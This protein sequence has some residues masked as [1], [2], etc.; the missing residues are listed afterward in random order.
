MATAHLDHD[1]LVRVA[2]EVAD[3]DGWP[4]LT[5]SRVAEAVRRHVTS[6]YGH[7]DGLEGLRREV[8]LLALEELAEALWEAALGR[9]G[10]DAL[11][12]ILDVY[13]AYQREHPGRADALLSISPRDR[14]IRRLAER[15][16][17]PFYATLRSYGLDDRAAV[18]AQ[19]VIS[20]TIRGFGISESRGHYGTRRDADATF[21]QVRELFL[22]ALRHGGWPVPPG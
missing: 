4:N 22:V 12:A 21:A 3:R 8:Q 7:V 5:M 19:R 18:L 14:E 1:E 13:R 6:L 17:A 20:A 10:D 9:T 11:V 16:V 15:V 2:A